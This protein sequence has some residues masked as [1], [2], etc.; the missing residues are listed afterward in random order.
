[1][2]PENTV[3]LRNT[4]ATLITACG[5]SHIAELWLRD[6][7]TTALTGALFGAG[8]LIVGIGL[9]GQSR[10]VLFLAILLP[11]AGVRLAL[12]NVPIESLNWLGLAQI[13]SACLVTIL[14]ALVL[15]AVRHQPST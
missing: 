2:S 14:S 13:T 12:N 10:F 15:Y 8:Y 5:T 11:M 6:I 7:D 3:R 4:A 9:F 1:M